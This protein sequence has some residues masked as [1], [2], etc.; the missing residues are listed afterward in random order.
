ME[1]SAKDKA[2]EVQAKSRMLWAKYDKDLDNVLNGKEQI[3]KFL[4]H[5]FKDAKYVSD[6]KSFLNL[7]QLIDEEVKSAVAKKKMTGK[8]KAA[9]EQN[10]N[11]NQAQVQNIVNRLYNVKDDKVPPKS[12]KSRSPTKG[13]KKKTANEKAERLLKGDMK[14]LTDNAPPPRDVKGSYAEFYKD[15]KAMAKSKN[16]NDE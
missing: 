8:A 2:K 14:T 1:P 7:E 16:W 10:P 12:A 6:F 3:N 9:F 4:A 15:T 5:S 13:D 11:L